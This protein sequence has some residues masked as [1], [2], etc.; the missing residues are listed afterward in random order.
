MTKRHHQSPPPPIYDRVQLV[1]GPLSGQRLRVQRQ[2][3]ALLFLTG[4]DGRLSTY[5]GSTA[6]GKLHHQRT[7]NRQ[8]RRRGAKGATA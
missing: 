1:G 5:T 3:Q 2:V 4:T 8:P 7:V 6:S